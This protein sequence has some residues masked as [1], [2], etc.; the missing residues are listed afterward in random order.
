[1]KYRFKYFYKILTTRITVLNNFIPEEKRKNKK[2]KPTVI[3]LLLFLSCLIFP[4]ENST[5]KVLTLNVWSGLDYKGI[6]K[7]G[8]YE[9]E[10]IR[11]KRFSFLKEELKKLNPDIIFLQEINPAASY[12][13]GLAD[14]LD[15]DE[16]HQVC[17]AGIK[18][19]PFGIPVNLKEGD[20]ILARKNLHLE[21]FDA[22]KL[23]GGF[24]LHG[25]LL[26]IHFCEANFALIGKIEVNEKE[27]I[28]LNSHLKSGI[29]HSD[30]R[31][32]Y[33]RKIL[34]YFEY[35]DTNELIILGGDLNAEINSTEIRLLESRFLICSPPPGEFSWDP[36]KNTNIN[37]STTVNSNDPAALRDAE[38]DNIPKTLDHILIS[39]NFG[40]ESIRE[41]G[42]VL[43]K[44]SPDDLYI[45]DHFGIMTEINLPVNSS[46]SQDGYSAIEALPIL[47]YDTDAGFGYGAKAFFLN[48][49]GHK[50][51]FDFTL[52]N[53]TKGE[54]WYRFIFS[55]PDFELRQRTIYSAFDLEIDYDKMI[56]NNFFG[57]GGN[58]RFD[59]QEFYTSEPLEI[60]FQFSRGLTPDFVWQTGLKFKYSRN[61]NFEEES[62]LK[63]LG[64]LNS[65][66][67]RYYSIYTN[68]RYDTRN[69][70][71]NPSKG[72]V[73]QGEIEYVPDL[74]INNVIF[75]RYSLTA[76]YYYKL[77]Y[78]KTIFACR[79]IFQG[80]SG[81]N[82]PVQNLLPLGGNN[83]IR[84]YQ[85]NRFMDKTSAL[86]NLELRFPVY[87]RFGGIAGVD[88][89]NVWD[90]IKSM[91]LD[92][93]KINPAAGLR[94]YFDTFVVRIDIGFGNETTGFYLNF[95]HIF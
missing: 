88:F 39:K 11:E 37:Y 67:S 47:S 18:F 22:V 52:F 24:G 43:N 8:E 93:W 6:F 3:F 71:I 17:N 23:S 29:N 78:P 58:S 14:F 80:M 7:M 51:S 73:L 31:T 61:Y 38:Y 34:D 87:W 16:I 63:D 35:S 46:N 20:A 59:D 91:S 5:L 41:T 89:G 60:K 65:S 10:E 84:G 44:A 26:S 50:E 92:D 4:Q 66:I 21:E 95:G 36:L 42:V 86:A 12:A 33:V 48:Q 53:S 76:Q 30:N 77:F 90:R 69:S 82:I 57:I 32:E 83:T 68:L 2:M 74:E 1:M 28:L 72:V 9:A 13:S 15:Y 56:S 55:I 70:F 94:F 25:D 19:G 64:G 54:R 79:V 49:F 75:S 45:S 85:Q 27:I 62:Y 40:E 81:N